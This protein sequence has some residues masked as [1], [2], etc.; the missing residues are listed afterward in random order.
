[1][2]IPGRDGPV[3]T[4]VRG[5]NARRVAAEHRRALRHFLATGDASVLDPFRGQRVGGVELLT[6][7]DLAEYFYETGQLEGG[8]YPQARPA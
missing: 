2:E 7:P 8:P 1:M 3:F 5:S 6:D 4:V